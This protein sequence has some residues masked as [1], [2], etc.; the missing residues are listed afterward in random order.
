MSEALPAVGVVGL[1]LIGGGIALDLQRADQPVTG[2][3][4]DPTVRERAREL[5]V[6]TRESLAEL[7][8]GVDLVVVA[9]PLAAVPDTLASVREQGRDVLVTDVASVK[10]PKGLGADALARYVGGHP[11]AGSER[12]GIDAARPGLFDGAPWFL[13]PTPDTRTTDLVTAIAFVRALSAAPVP[14]DAGTHDRYV[15]MLSHVPHLMA[16]GLQATAT[17]MMGDGLQALGGGSFRDVTRVAASEPGFWAEV[18]HANRDAVTEAL[19]LLLARLE[20]GAELLD[21][22]KSLERHLAEG[23]RQPTARPADAGLEVRL[24]PASEPLGGTL[25]E[26]VAHGAAGNAI[27]DVTVVDGRITLHLAP[28]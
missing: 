16:Y 20:S 23:R 4:V 22:P 10:E 13:T 8:S 27:T 12:S 26:L 2:F 21:A 6:D 24:P 5:G 17:A 28:L 7:V 3:D 11:M 14:V 15:A 1:G 9:V 25:G 19:R 18:L